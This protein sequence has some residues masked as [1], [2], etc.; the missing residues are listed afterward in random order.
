LSHFFEGDSNQ[1]SLVENNL[2]S[3]MTLLASQTGSGK[4][5]AYLLPVLHSLKWTELNTVD[6]PASNGSGVPWAP[7]A[8][9]VAP[10]HEL[11]R[12]LSRFAKSLSHAIKLRVR[13]LSQANKSSS[14]KRFDAYEP[15]HMVSGG[16]SSEFEIQ[17]NE[18]T[19]HGGLANMDR[20]VDVLVGTIGRVLDLTRGHGWKDEA[21]KLMVRNPWE[22]KPDGATER[23]HRAS[24]KPSI[25]FKN[26]EWVVMDEADVVYGPDF[27]HSTEM[28]LKDIAAARKGTLPRG[29]LSRSNLPFNL[30]LCTATIPNALNHYVSTNYPSMTKLISNRLHDLPKSITPE[31]VAWTGGRR[32]ADVAARLKAVWA[33]DADEG[34]KPHQ[35]SKVLVFCNRSSKAERLSAYLDTRGIPSISLI[36]AVEGSRR[37]KYNDNSISSFLKTRGSTQKGQAGDTPSSVDAPPRVLVTTSLLSRG[38]DFDDSVRHVF[39]VD[40]PRNMVD[41]I[42]RAGR[43]GRAGKRGKVVIFSKSIGRG[44]ARVRT[45]VRGEIMRKVGLKLQ[46]KKRDP[47]NVFA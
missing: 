27:I 25:D 33:E 30:I 40:E 3:S 4:S 39:I 28:L 38:L 34:K 8:L 15:S 31:H 17:R 5:I 24:W 29:L 46:T 18:T 23:I 7:K 37:S 35:Y 21:E 1:S 13:C 6:N 12:Q 19:G 32:E 9:I 26:V 43:T 36:R 2:G 14:M 22:K 20:S 41:F 45:G 16:N 47:H 44:S 42:H 11:S 10:T